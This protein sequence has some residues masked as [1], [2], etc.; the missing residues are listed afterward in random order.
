MSEGPIVLNADDVPSVSIVIVNLNGRM[1]LEECLDALAAQNYPP[2]CVE[3]ILVDNGSTDGS[4]EFVRQNYPA[5][6]ILEAGRNLGFAG[7]N[8]WGARQAKGEYLA[9]INNDSRADPDWLR[10]LV[11][12]LEAHPEY[13]C[14]IAKVLTEDDSRIDFVGPALNI[15]GRAFQLYEGISAALG[16]GEE[17]KEVF[18]PCGNG[19]LIRRAVFLD[20]GGFDEDYIAYYEDVDLGWRLW[21]YGYK[22]IFVPRAILYHRRH[23]TGAYFPVEQRYFLSELNALRTIIKNYEEDNLWRVLSL[24]LFLGVK[25]A[26]DQAGVD[27]NRYYF[28]LPQQGGDPQEGVTTPEPSMTRVA[29]SFLIAIEQ[30]AK[31]MSQLMAKRKI[32]QQ[33]RIRSDEEIFTRFPLRPD[34]PLFPWREYT[35]LQTHLVQTLD[36]PKALVPKYG[37]HLLIITHEHIGPKM[38]GPGVRAWEMACA[39][40]R[41]CEVTLAAPGSP[42][43]SHPG[44]RIVG[45]DKNN[46]YSLQ[47]YIDCADI[48]L[49]MGPLFA[50]IPQLQN[51]P[52]PTIV[53]LYDPFELEKLTQ[54]LS[55][56]PYQRAH[57]DTDSIID[58]LLETTLGDFFICASEDQR[59][60]WLGALLAA[61][62]INTATY[63]QDPT[64][65]NLIDVV[66]F[67]LSST[68]P[69]KTRPVLKGV[70]SGISQDDKVLLWNGGIWEWLDPLTLVQ[71]LIEVLKVRQDVKLVFA[72][73]HHFDT[74][75]VPEMPVALQIVSLCKQYGLLDKNVFFLDWIP[76]DERGE[77]LLEADLGVTLSKNTIE[78]HF[79]Y[80][81]RIIDCIWA[82]LPVII[83]GGDV[84]AETI[85]QYRLGYV[86]PQGDPHAVACAILDAL[87]DMTLREHVA[88]TARSLAPALSWDQA[89]QPIVRFVERANFAPD[90]LEAARL[91][92]QMRHIRNLEAHIRNLEAHI[93]AIYR[94]RVMRLMRKVNTLLGRK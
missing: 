23:Q 80:R 3:I 13:A 68:P 9:F 74:Q 47:P 49:A 50:Q 22:V 39:L 26:L 72:A 40:S 85:T 87:A 45:Y 19:M 60:F 51:L 78:S 64:L 16:Y 54:S 28:G 21:L 59:N 24:S 67:G 43:R 15:Y 34:N 73:G 32:I 42:S 55:M 86:V 20:I 62:R 63:A 81:S 75:T 61:G 29:V 92:N 12:T 35:V 56:D 89:V 65:R 1:W 2:E 76:Y 66:P 88:Q 71:A 44:M 27:R 36:I 5:V 93:E 79:A 33:R 6:R 70:V 18:A 17:T 84:L 58:L 46:L 69:Q 53:D 37:S 82:G 52:K 25:R 30:V 83:T 38:A 57:L 77:Y 91:A 94:G 8:N 11:E 7:G 4:I 48:I 14:A 31:E 10:A 90:A 41:Y